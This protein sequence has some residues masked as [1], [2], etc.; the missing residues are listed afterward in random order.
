MQNQNKDI[1]YNNIPKYKAAELKRITEIGAPMKLSKD[2][3]LNGSQNSISWEV[4]RNADCWALAQTSGS[5]MWGL[6]PAIYAL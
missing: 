3:I 5:E 2:Q 6:G 4:I 1:L